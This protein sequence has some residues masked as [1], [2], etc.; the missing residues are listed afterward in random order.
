MMTQCDNDVHNGGTDELL[1]T[2]DSELRK[3]KNHGS[4]LSTRELDL[5][6]WFPLPS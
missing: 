2:L 4:E 5:R 1:S 6:R 3:N